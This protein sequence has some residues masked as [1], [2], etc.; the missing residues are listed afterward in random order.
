MRRA[1]CLILWPLLLVSGSAVTNQ[2]SPSEPAPR[3]LVLDTRKAD[4][5]QKE[6]DL[7]AAAGH[8]VLSGNA[9]YLVL[10][11]ER[12]PEAEPVREY[13]LLRD[14]GKELA[15]ASAEGFRFMPS[16]LGA[17]GVA[18]AIVERDPGAPAGYEYVIVDTT[19]TST[20]EREIVGALAQ[21]YHVAGLASDNHGHFAVLERP[22]GGD[23]SAAELPPAGDRVKLLAANSPSTLQAELS[24]HAV[25][26]YR[27]LFAS[28]AKETLLW[29]ER[30]ETPAEAVEYRVLSTTKSDTLQRE[31]NEA[32]AAGFRFLPRTLTAVQRT[33]PLFG[34]YAH[35]LGAV[36]EKAAPVPA[37]EY[38]V[39]GT[40]RV[41][42]LQK[43]LQDSAARGYAVTRLILSYDEQVLVME[44]PQSLTRR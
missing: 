36:M 27:V 8:R 15:R 24:A 17:R 29:L 43:E 14:L 19:R 42:T 2:P 6:L 30:S 39:V 35:E 34:A 11:L 20:L 21:G 22:R 12:S 16:T 28:A 41:S 37:V 25:L 32:A 40:R 9:A 3:Y 13:R 44:R 26:G 18:T 38:L 10:V 7:A 31:M 5:L 4:S 33:A 23:P 1:M